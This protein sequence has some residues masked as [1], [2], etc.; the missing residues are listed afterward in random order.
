MSHQLDYTRMMK[1]MER[2]TKLQPQNPPPDTRF[3]DEPTNK[4]QTI[5]QVAKTERKRKL[6]AIR[7]KPQLVPD[8]DANTQYMQKNNYLQQKQRQL[9]LEQAKKEL[10]EQK[11]LL[12]L[13]QEQLTQKKL[14]Q[15]KEKNEQTVLQR[16]EKIKKLNDQEFQRKKQ[17]SQVSLDNSLL[18]L[19][20]T[21]VK[22]QIEDYHTLP[23]EQYNRLY[24]VNK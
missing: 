19:N 22:K 14:I 1:I 9:E 6:L 3:I 8:L 13:E 21:L 4:L 18:S 5:D 7:K 11:R 17:Q 24:K 23:R 16:E 10:A 20:G 12:K 2:I 15:L